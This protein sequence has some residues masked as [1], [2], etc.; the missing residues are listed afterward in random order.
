MTLGLITLLSKA[1][2]FLRDVLLANYYGISS[3]SDAYILATTIPIIVFTIF[4]A[5][6]NANYIPAYH[7]VNVSFGKSGSDK[8]TL[9][10]LNIFLV[11][12]CFIALLMFCFPSIFVYMFASGLDEPTNIK[13]SKFLKITS[14][15]LVMNLVCNFVKNYLQ[16]NDKFYH[17]VLA[18]IPM[19]VIVAVGIFYS[20]K[21]N[22]SDLMVYGFLVGAFVQLFVFIPAIKNLNFRYS[23]SIS[24]TKE[25]NIFFLMSIP[26]V[27]QSFAIQIN[28]VVDQNVASL[29]TSGG[30]SSLSYAKQIENVIYSL[31]ISVVLMVSFSRISRAFA[32]NNF[33]LFQLL[34]INSFLIMLALTLPASFGLFFFGDYVV[35]VVYG[36]G[37]FDQESV[38]ITGGILKYASIG[39]VFLAF[40]QLFIKLFYI[41]KNTKTPLYIYVFSLSL[42][43]LLT[44]FFYN[45]TDL[46]LAGITLATSVSYIFNMFF[47]YYWYDSLYGLK[48]EAEHWGFFIKLLFSSTTMILLTKLFVSNAPYLAERPLVILFTCV[49]IYCCCLFLTCGKE[50]KASLNY[51]GS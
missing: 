16:A 38:M 12:V 40:N 5:T 42:N 6:V 10:I 24:Y 35:G 20:F 18:T 19:N 46:G 28:T 34:S 31:L 11:M 48:F 36:R 49:F 33:S 30:V 44:L 14:L 27:L 41:H 32:T 21:N 1:V 29:I 22:D 26:I 15:T 37:N 47:L 39:I 9:N 45:Y 50:V 3:V 23:P 51:F 7:Q 17:Q 25:T 2:A 4:A 43:I 8:F 13:A